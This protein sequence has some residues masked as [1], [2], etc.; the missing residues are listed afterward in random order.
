MLFY[1]ILS[2]I[3]R[4]STRCPVWPEN[5]FF[6]FHTTFFPLLWSAQFLPK[7][8]KVC[9]LRSQPSCYFSHPATIFTLLRV[10]LLAH[11]RKSA[12]THPRTSQITFGHW[13]HL[14]V[15]VC[16]LAPRM[17]GW[18]GGVI[19]GSMWTVVIKII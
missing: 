18:F 2:F 9:Y 6:R 14:N 12:T 16:G 8:S 11:P 1:L 15:P 10:Y 19:S 17:G 3:F 7:K 5:F 13:H 4:F